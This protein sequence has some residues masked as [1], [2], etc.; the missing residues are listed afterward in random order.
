MDSSN[1][2]RS[3]GRSGAWLVVGILMILFALAGALLYVGWGW[4]EAD[5]ASTMTFAADVAMTFGIVV[6]LVLGGGLISLVYY[7]SRRRRDF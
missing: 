1:E 7:G 3:A 5:P 2:F 6:T 4:D